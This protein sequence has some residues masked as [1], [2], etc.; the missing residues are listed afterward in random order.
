MAKTKPIGVRFD[1]EILAEFKKS[2]IADTAQG[3]L[4]F[5]IG[6]YKGAKQKVELSPKRTLVVEGKPVEITIQGKTKRKD[7]PVEKSNKKDKEMPAGLTR[8][9]KMR[10]MRE[11]E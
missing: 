3:V 11:N 9:A 7:Q 2:K 10:W 6:F 8:S 4:N 1:E 5:L